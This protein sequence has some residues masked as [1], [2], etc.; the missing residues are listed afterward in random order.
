MSYK[1]WERAFVNAVTSD[2]AW[3]SKWALWDLPLLV[4]D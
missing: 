1:A 4:T 2:R 3:A